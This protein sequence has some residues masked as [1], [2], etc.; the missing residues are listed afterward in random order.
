VD[1]IYH[2][3]ETAW[4]AAARGRGASVSNGLGMLVH[5][6]AL[7]LA[8]WTGTEPPLEAMWAAVG[9]DPTVDGRPRPGDR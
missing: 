1:L 4:L 8:L 2:P 9:G 3:A 7:Q 6:A 5:Q